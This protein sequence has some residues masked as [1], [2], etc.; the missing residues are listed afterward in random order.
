MMLLPRARDFAPT[1]EVATVLDMPRPLPAVS[2]TDS[3][4]Q[5]FALADLTGR[6]TLLFFGFTNCPD[7]CPLTLA[8]IA[9]ALQE[10]RQGPADLVPEVV[11]ISIDP[12]RDSP[13]RIRAYLGGFDPGFIGATADETTLA[14]LLEALSVTVHKEIHGDET[15]NV[16]HNGTIYV[17]DDNSRW[18]AIF[19]GSQH[20]A[21]TVVS[22]YRAIRRLQ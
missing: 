11:F 1:V 20:N 16:V 3:N 7:V 17:L 10:L 5:P 13:A 8:V 6:Y 2:L 22:D 12:N 18:T 4:G 21:D 14:P 9:E 15:Y 19:G